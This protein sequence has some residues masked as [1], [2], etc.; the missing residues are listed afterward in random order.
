MSERNEFSN[1]ADLYT[2]AEDWQHEA[3]RPHIEKPSCGWPYQA[4]SWS[5][6]IEDMKRNAQTC[7]GVIDGMGAIGALPETEEPTTTPSFEGPIQ[8]FPAGGVHAG[9]SN[10]GGEYVISR[11]GYADLFGQ[12]ETLDRA[13]TPKDQ[14]EQKEF[15]RRLLTTKNDARARRLQ[16]VNYDV[17]RAILSIRPKQAKKAL[18]FCLRNHRLSPSGQMD[19]AKIVF[20][21]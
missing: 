16:L 3:E 12:Y 10:N 13:T 7:K 14:E 6:F 15:M 4:G 11:N 9:Q 17:F 18:N 19:L 2:E 1:P 8:R 5:T 21:A 20:K